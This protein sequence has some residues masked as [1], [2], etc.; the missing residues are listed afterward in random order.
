MT[1]PYA[2]AFIDQYQHIFF[3]C[4]QRHVHDASRGRVVS[5]QQLQ[6][7][8]HLDAAR[9]TKV[10][11]LASHMGLSHSSVS[12]TIDRLQRDGYVIRERSSADG[13]VTFVRLTGAGEEVRDA[14]RVLEPDIV[15][16]VLRRLTPSER[17]AAREAMAA[18]ARAAKEE[19]SARRSSQRG[20]A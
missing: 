6:I 14:Q 16:S 7:L 4:H 10:G 15:A 12:L 13:R 11:E 2:D 1:A 9:Q 5:E 3:A 20:A 17:Q 8:S 19:L 18:L